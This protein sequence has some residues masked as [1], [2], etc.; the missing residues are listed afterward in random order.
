M[1]YVPQDAAALL[2]T[3]GSTVAEE[4]AFG[5]ENRGMDRRLMHGAVMH[6]AEAAGLA[7][8]LER[9]PATLSGGELRRLAVACAAITRPGVLVLDEPLGSLDEAGAASVRHW[10]A[11]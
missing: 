5:L 4:L 2:S 10:S 8:L 3:V 11:V 9:D 6:A 7:A 1:G